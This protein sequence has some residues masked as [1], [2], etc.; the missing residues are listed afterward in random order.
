[1]GVTE[2]IL[3][4]I[5]AELE[6]A[7][8][9]GSLIHDP[10][11]HHDRPQPTAPMGTLTS[12][13]G[14]KPQLQPTHWSHQRVVSGRTR[15]WGFGRCS[16]LRDNVPQNPGCRIGKG[17]LCQMLETTASPRSIHSCAPLSCRVP[18][19]PVKRLTLR[20]AFH[21]PLLTPPPPGRIPR[22]PHQCSGQT[23]PKSLSIPRTNA[24]LA[25]HSHWASLLKGYWA[26]PICTYPN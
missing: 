12:R 19:L 3:I 2:H 1:M 11:Q 14:H 10:R 21:M 5:G 24:N 8:R 4:L 6:D 15:V 20:A 18:C 23:S 17:A 7:T 13:E 22:N 25:P 9:S 16:Q 26:P